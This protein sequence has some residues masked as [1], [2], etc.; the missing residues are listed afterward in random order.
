MCKK[1]GVNA[2]PQL[3]LAGI[4]ISFHSCF[5]QQI[6]CTKQAMCSHT[7]GIGS[8]VK[9]LNDL[10]HKAGL[11]WR[12]SVIVLVAYLVACLWGCVYGAVIRHRGGIYITFSPQRLG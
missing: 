12:V 10:V 6:H 3:F 11:P 9:H 5:S 2:Q 7:Y 4:Y 8:H 1:S